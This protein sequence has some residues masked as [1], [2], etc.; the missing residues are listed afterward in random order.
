[1]NSKGSFFRISTG[2]NTSPDFRCVSLINPIDRDLVQENRE[3]FSPLKDSVV[4]VGNRNNQHNI[5]WG[6]LQ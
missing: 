2:R 1:M 3:A 4:A 6:N 5:L